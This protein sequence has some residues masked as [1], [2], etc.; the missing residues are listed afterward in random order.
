MKFGIDGDDVASFSGENMSDIF[1]G[2]PFLRVPESNGR[3][4]VTTFS[5]KNESLPAKMTA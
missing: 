5:R 3:P 2:G 1:H 4:K